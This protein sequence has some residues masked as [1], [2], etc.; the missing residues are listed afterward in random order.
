M[1]N[2]VAARLGGGARH[3]WPF[4]TE[5]AGA[6]PDTSMRVHTGLADRPTTLP[7]SVEVIATDVPKGVSPRRLWW[8][9]IEVP[10][11]ARWGEVLVSP[12]NFGP[13]RVQRP[14][15]LFSRNPTYFDRA[16]TEDAPI[17]LQ[18]RMAAYR[19][20]A[21]ACIEAAD[22]VVVPSH[23]MRNMISPYVR[24]T[25][26]VRVI[27]HGF[28]PGQ[29]RAHVNDE[30]LAAA[31]NWLRHEVRLLHV[32]NPAPH[33]N[34]PML[35]RIV[36]MLADRGV[37]AGLAVTFEPTYPDNSV[38]SFRADVERLGIGERVHLLGTV[39]QLAVFPLYR[40]AQVFLY[41]SLTESFGFPL[42]EAL[43]V[44]TPIVAS[45]IASNRETALSHA[46][47]HDPRDL[48]G[49]V[50]AIE[51]AL[52]DSFDPRPGSA[53]ADTYSWPAYARRVAAL[54]GELAA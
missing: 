20:L 9:Q 25:E 1:I 31:Q 13:L 11:A 33:K 19:R 35:A 39:P 26:H 14:Q 47:Y 44:G 15:L 23:A 28:D 2:G 41:P 21:S 17:R 54:I 46:H 3:F 45:D 7:A 18:A 36:R 8:D 53:H 42:L 48:I 49:A 12:L 22:L 30:P 10:R 34:L 6:M 5:L 4:V 40:R 27:P 24:S 52:G 51:T 16:F 37:D 43:A 38:A 50:A 29:A 32:S